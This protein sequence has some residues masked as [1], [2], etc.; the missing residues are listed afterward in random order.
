MKKL[1]Y[2]FLFLS[3]TF[4]FSQKIITSSANK[5]PEW[6]EQIPKGQ[7]FDYYSGIGTSMNSLE[8][9]KKS[10]LS[11]AIS[12]IIYNTDIKV[13]LNE[14]FSSKIKETDNQISFQDEIIKDIKISGSSNLIKGLKKE[15]EYWQILKADN[16]KLYHFWVLLKVSKTGKSFSKFDSDKGYGIA[17]IWRSSLI[18]GWGQFYKGEDTK[19]WTF[20]A[21]ETIL[22]SSIFI[23]MHFSSSFEDKANME[24]DL[25]NRQFYN[26]KADQFYTAS[27]I[28]AVLAG[29]V[30]V[31]NIFDSVTSKGEKIYSA[32]SASQTLFT[33]NYNNQENLYIGFKINF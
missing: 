25:D 3:F 24:R 10:A 8:A 11:N 17:P 33:I 1:F 26:D 18:P 16:G 30:Y 23:T 9:A 32:N 15:E 21:T 4:C 27:I 14:T 12:E 20:L 13:E 2:Y 7:Q 28:S 6:I 5:K 19:G 31:Y 22:V 29:A